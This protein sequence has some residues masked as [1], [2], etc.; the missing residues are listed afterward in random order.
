MAVS[1]DD[2]ATRS[3]FGAL[4]QGVVINFSEMRTR[5]AAYNRVVNELNAMSDTE[6][7]QMKV[8]RSMIP[9][10]ARQEADLT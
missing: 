10:V 7:A 5:R 1:F 9:Q 3:S 8:A 2:K 6:L 4:I